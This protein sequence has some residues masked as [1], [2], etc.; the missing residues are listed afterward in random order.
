[1]FG[2]LAFSR[3]LLG[4]NFVWWTFVRVDFCLVFFCYR[5]DFCSVN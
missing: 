3:L 4:W 2:A 1:M 5:V